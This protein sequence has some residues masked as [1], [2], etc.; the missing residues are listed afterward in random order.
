VIRG[1]SHDARPDATACL[2]RSRVGY[3]VGLAD[4]RVL[5]D[6]TAALT[7]DAAIPGAEQVAEKVRNLDDFR[8]TARRWKD[9]ER[10]VIAGIDAPRCSREWAGQRHTLH[11]DQPRR[12]IPLAL[13]GSFLRSPAGREPARAA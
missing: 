5:L 9:V 12:H 8:S 4:N 2:E 7:D 3:A 10:H 1:D 11:R 6:R 13:R